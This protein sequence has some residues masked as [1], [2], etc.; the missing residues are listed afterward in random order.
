MKEQLSEYHHTQT[1]EFLYGNRELPI[2]HVMPEIINTLKSNNRLCLVSETGSGK[3]TQVPQELYHSGV[4]GDK[5]LYVVENTVA[6]A[7]EVAKRVSD[8]M[9]VPIGSSVG[10][11]TR[12]EKKLS[13]KSKIIFV[14]NGIFKNIIRNDPTLSKASMVIFDEF[15]E[16]YLAS[17]IGLALT[18]E[19]QKKGCK[20]KFILMSATLNSE[21][22]KKHFTGIPLVEA[23]G[24]QYPVQ[25]FFSDRDIDVFQ[26]PIEAAK[27]SIEIL[28]KTPSGDMLLFMPGKWEIDATIREIKRLHPDAYT[29]PL[30]A[31]LPKEE[32]SKVFEKTKKRKIIVSTNV[33]E[34]GLTI[35]GVKYVIDS[36]VARMNDYDP[37]NDASKLGILSCAK[38]SIRQRK[39]RAGRTSPGEY[40]ALFT[41]KDFL[42]RAPST[43]PEIL[44][45]PLRSLL[46]QLKAMGYY[47]DVDPIRF[48]DSPN[49]SQ[50]NSAK[51]QLK[52]LGA[53]DTNN[54]SHLSRFG[55]DLSELD[56][57]PREGT[58]ILNGA[59]LGVVKE[60]A[61]L[62]AIRS[63][64]KRIFNRPPPQRDLADNKHR[65]F[66]GNQK[67]GYKSDMFAL[68]HAFHEGE[69]TNFDPLWCKDH[70]VS[71]S[72]LKEI[73]Q[74]SFD[75]LR[76]VKSLGYQ[77]ENIS[78]SP[79]KIL[80]A[81]RS[82]FPDRVFRFIKYGWY[83]NILTKDRA[84]VSRDSILY[85][86]PMII[87]NEFIHLQKP[88][89]L[90]VPTITM[91]TSVIQ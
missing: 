76:Q 37:I 18:E 71:R 36:G 79:E 30:H 5:I 19:A 39:G 1:K 31:E 67:S 84:V 2:W 7:S 87:A 45:S 32:R 59:K 41:E 27:K 89:G 44:R 63:C 54:D 15:D 38:D 77:T 81:I 20:T 33:A 68:L 8:E 42:S 6:V 40:F 46:L 82:A 69:K 65:E 90:I 57:D 73:R 24:R 74:T 64:S 48:M 28:K 29:L 58:M 4:L 9:H 35:D 13:D 60:M 47:K 17:D 80:K 49:I 25:A 52:M 12:N 78:V 3:S 11:I 72:A 10:Y 70:F 43:K 61:I 26:M 55:K 86:E 66:R 75:L 56:C 83:E 91:A 14:T 23:K 22:I 50:W 88:D 62:S 34:R 16:R 51:Q 21:K 53:L 85:D